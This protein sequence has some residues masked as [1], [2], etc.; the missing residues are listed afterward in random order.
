MTITSKPRNLKIYSHIIGGAKFPLNP[1]HW[2]R[3][4]MREY[5]D[6]LGR[7][8]ALTEAE[9]DHWERVC[10][11]RKERMEYHTLY[12]SYEL[13][14]QDVLAADVGIESLAYRSYPNCPGLPLASHAL[15][16]ALAEVKA[17]AGA[18]G[19]KAA[20][21]R[22]VAL[23]ERVAKRRPALRALSNGIELPAALLIYV[24]GNEVRVQLSGDVLAVVP[25]CDALAPRLNRLGACWLRYIRLLLAY[26]QV[27]CVCEYNASTQSRV[28]LC[29][30][31]TPRSGNR[32]GA[33][34]FRNR[35]G[36][37]CLV[38][39]SVQ[40]LYTSRPQDEH[41]QRYENAGGALHGAPAFDRLRDVAVE[42]AAEAVMRHVPPFERLDVAPPTR[43]A[44]LQRAD[45]VSPSRIDVYA[46]DR[47][48]TLEDPAADRFEVFQTDQRY[49]QQ[50]PYAVF[51]S[52]ALAI[53]FERSNREV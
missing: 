7:R 18:R 33:L 3:A 43:E 41:A 47:R 36:S 32:Q 26:A 15:A 9:A 21:A 25:A 22:L 20:A 11:S 16:L 8:K 38:E 42:A 44:V 46:G 2:T 39:R 37:R 50:E 34:M 49:Y 17:L 24:R 6:Q 5:R 48:T 1:I 28:E 35:D 52:L 30:P 4:E 31:V 14:P 19:T 12:T 23:C 27:P 13:P 45:D 10:E 40:P 29:L 53:D 51:R